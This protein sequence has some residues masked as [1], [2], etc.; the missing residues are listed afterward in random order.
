MPDHTY[1]SHVELRLTATDGFGKSVTVA[2]R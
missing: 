2:R 1:P